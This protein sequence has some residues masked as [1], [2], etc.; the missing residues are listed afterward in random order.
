MQNQR[1]RLANRRA[2]LPH[3]ARVC[4]RCGYSFGTGFI[5][6]IDRKR[7]NVCRDCQHAIDA[8][9][10]RL[11]NGPADRAA[12]IEKLLR[13]LGINARQDWSRPMSPF[14]VAAL[15]GFRE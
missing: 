5:W 7:L 1:D 14:L 11:A 9:A 4:D 12:V 8:A 6:V 2:S 15:L 13:R 10:D 3:P